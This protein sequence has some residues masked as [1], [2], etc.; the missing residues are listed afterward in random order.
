MLLPEAYLV[1]GQVIPEMGFE[2]I[3]VSGG[4]FFAVED[5][6]VKVHLVQEASLHT[7]QGK[8]GVFPIGKEIGVKRA[9]GTNEV[10]A[11]EQCGP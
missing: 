2:E 9:D 7:A 11:Y 6:R 5:H 10:G 1:A 3:G 8:V 4:K